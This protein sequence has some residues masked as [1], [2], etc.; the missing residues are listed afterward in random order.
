VGRIQRPGRKPREKQINATLV[1]QKVLREK[2]KKKKKK[3]KYIPMSLS[4]RPDNQLPITFSSFF[5]EFQKSH[6]STKTS[7][8]SQSEQE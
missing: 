7:S 4:Y 8:Q 3:G 6:V 1:G 2:K 5:F